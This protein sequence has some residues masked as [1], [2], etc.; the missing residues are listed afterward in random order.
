MRCDFLEKVSLLIDGELTPVEADQ[1]RVHL[2]S[3]RIC[4]HTERDFMRLRH[5][6]RSHEFAS[7]LLAQRQTLWRIVALKN[8]PLWRRKIAVPAPV[9]ALVVVVLAALGTWVGFSGAAGSLR[10]TSERTGEQGA[11]RPS[12]DGFDLSRFDR[13]ERAVIYKTP[14][15]KP[16]DETW[17]P[18]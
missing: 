10:R 12:E 6:I 7:D 8:V 15:T 3:C 16:G 14:R 1:I 4:Q 18:K 9:V 17:G 2:S 5:S 11:I 13:G